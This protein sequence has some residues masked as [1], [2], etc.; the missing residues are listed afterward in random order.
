[1]LRSG[2]DNNA[3]KRAIR[4]AKVKQKISGQFKEEQAAQNFAII[5]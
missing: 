1:M 2:K 4:N 3:S 5:R